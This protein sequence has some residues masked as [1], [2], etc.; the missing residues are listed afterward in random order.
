MQLLDVTPLGQVIKHHE[1]SP[2]ATA[3][4]IPS[5]SDEARSGVARIEERLLVDHSRRNERTRAM[6]YS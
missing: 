1:Y 3:K 4:D 6:G 5:Q 2:R